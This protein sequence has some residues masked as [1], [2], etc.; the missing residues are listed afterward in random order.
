VEGGA[1]RLIGRQRFAVGLEVDPEAVLDA[2]QLRQTTVTDDLSGAR[3][4]GREDAWPGQDEQ[5]SGIGL[6][7]VKAA[8]LE[9]GLE[10]LDDL[11]RKLEVGVDG[12]QDQ[13]TNVKLA[14]TSEAV[15][16]GAFELAPAERR[17]CILT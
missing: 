16:R 6:G 1:Q 9:E 3:R 8:R 17:Q 14:V 12:D 13:L 2:G 10:T 15:G 5:V 7:Q 4:P 11:A